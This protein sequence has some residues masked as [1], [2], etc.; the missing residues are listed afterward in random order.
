M[1]I[2][3]SEEKVLK[4]N[5]MMKNGWKDGKILVGRENKSERGKSMDRDH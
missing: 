3:Y 4:T 1:D 5:S 2:G